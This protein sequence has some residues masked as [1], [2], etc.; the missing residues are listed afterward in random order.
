MFT[1]NFLH[2]VVG[3]LMFVTLIVHMILG[4]KWLSGMRAKAASTSGLA[5]KQ[6]V[7]AAIVTLLA[8]VFVLMFVS[9]ILISN[10][11]TSFTGWALEGDWYLVVAYIH[12]VCA[13]VICAITIAHIGL[14]WISLFK[15]LK[16]PYNPSRRNAINTGVTALASAGIVA[17]GFAA[18]K[19]I[20]NWDALLKVIGDSSKEEESVAAQYLEPQIEE[21]VVEEKPKRERKRKKSSASNK[22]NSESGNSDSGVSA[23]NSSNSG[24][25]YSTQSTP[26]SSS[27]TPKSSSSSSKGSS[28]SSSG[29]SKRPSSNSSSSNSQSQSKPSS[30]PQSPAPSKPPSSSSSSICPLCGKRCSLSAPRCHKPYAAGLI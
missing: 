10:V 15:A 20:T 4:R 22:K 26:K 24:S 7:M 1:G 30:K 6:K 9:S 12:T 27:S 2:E 5:S 19:E 16:L 3:A 28:S 8:I 25:Q 21:E 11:L 13:Y 14:H 29:S 23:Q 17:V 18:S